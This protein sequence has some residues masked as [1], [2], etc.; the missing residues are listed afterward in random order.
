[1]SSGSFRIDLEE[2][3]AAARRIQSLV[4]ELEPLAAAVEAAVR[5]VAPV[6][7][8]TGPVG[9]ALLGAGPGSGGPGTGGLVGQQARALQGVHRFLGNSGRMAENLLLMCRQYREADGGHVAALKELLGSSGVPGLPPEAGAVPGGR[10][11]SAPARP[12][13]V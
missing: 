5:Q 1:M 9:A 13:A 3:E 6:S 8:G 11:P 10:G 7:Y 12:A 2:V 4:R